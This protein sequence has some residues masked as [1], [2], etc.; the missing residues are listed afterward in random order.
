[1]SHD[2]SPFSPNLGSQECEESGKERTLPACRAFPS[3]A[4][5]FQREAAST[6]PWMMC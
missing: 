2:D 6:A 5:G 3:P 1:M 4:S